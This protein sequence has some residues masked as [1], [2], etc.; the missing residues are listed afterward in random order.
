MERANESAGT[1]GGDTPVGAPVEGF[2]AE[3]T[4]AITGRAVS[5]AMASIQRRQAEVLRRISD[6]TAL[7]IR[8]KTPIPPP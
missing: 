1:A 4:T 7:A 2:E 6:I 8:K 3:E 5:E